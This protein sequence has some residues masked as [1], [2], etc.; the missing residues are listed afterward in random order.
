MLGSAERCSPAP[1]LD[2]TRPKL[3]VRE[4]GDSNSRPLAP[5]QV[6]SSELSRGD[7]R[8]AGARSREQL[9]S[10]AISRLKPRIPIVPLAFRTKFRRNS[11]L[12]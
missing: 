4:R 9:Q 10:P 8:E 6:L 5:K 7:Y 11:T 3:S 12:V 2:V 1:A